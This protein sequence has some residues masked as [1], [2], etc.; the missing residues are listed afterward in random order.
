MS[1]YCIRCGVEIEPWEIG[2][3]SGSYLCSHCYQEKVSHRAE[4]PNICTD[5]YKRIRE[6]ETNRKLGRTLCEKC[7]EEENRKMMEFQCVSC[8]HWIRDETLK[9]KM[10]D[11][12]IMCL[13]C[14]R[15]FGGG[16]L[17]AKV[18]A[19]CEKKTEHYYVSE[20]GKIYCDQCSIKMAESLRK[21][22]EIIVEI[23]EESPVIR[24]LRG[25]ITKMLKH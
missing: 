10:P 3:Y 15:K 11:G 23:E 21:P 24:K 2:I 17:A 14:Y 20:I 19:H 5:C 22:Q 8:K 12:R 9:R 4:Y 7:Y 13:D 1:D 25:V 6:N 16:K 18:C